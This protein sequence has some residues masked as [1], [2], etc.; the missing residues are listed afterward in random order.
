MEFEK[1]CQARQK[2]QQM[3]ADGSKTGI[4]FCLAPESDAHG[5]RVGPEVC[6][7]CPVFDAVER[8]IEAAK[9]APIDVQAHIDS[10]W[11]PCKFRKK[12]V[13]AGCCGSRI[14][15]ECTHEGCDYNGHEVVP[16][17]CRLCRLRTP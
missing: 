4:Y 13:R 2:I 5:R 14:E 1:P 12:H 6:N 15:I 9:A 3:A 11:L 16:E 8:R 17:I 7:V 10:R